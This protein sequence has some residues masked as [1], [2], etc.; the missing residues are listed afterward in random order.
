MRS[1][2]LV[3]LILAPVTLVQAAAP[4]NYPGNDI[5]IHAN[6]IH[7]NNIDCIDIMQ[8]LL[9]YVYDW[10]LNSIVSFEAVGVTKLIFSVSFF[11]FFSEL[12]KHWLPV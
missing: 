9:K 6:N 7:R 4:F 1:L 3:I 8:E 10:R 12:L 2:S 11:R 5:L